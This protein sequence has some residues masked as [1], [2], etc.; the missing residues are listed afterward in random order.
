M[1][2]TRRHD[3]MDILILTTKTFL[4]SQRHTSTFFPQ[5]LLDG[6]SK[7]QLRAKG[8]AQVGTRSDGESLSRSLSRTHRIAKP[9]FLQRFW[10]LFSKT[11][12][13]TWSADFSVKCWSEWRVFKTPTIIGDLYTLFQKHKFLRQR[14][15]TFLYDIYNVFDN[16]IHW[17]S[18][19]RWIVWFLQCFGHTLGDTIQN[20][21][22]LR[23]SRHRL[24]AGPNQNHS[25]FKNTVFTCFQKQLFRTHSF[26]GRK[27]C[28]FKKSLACSWSQEFHGY[29]DFD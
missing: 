3:S 20:T 17:A 13:F 27:T 23:A 24:R 18:I 8:K 16:V 7:L 29:P 21:W 9:C 25:F 2:S 5:A 28:S 12:F 14:R 15:Q 10:R 4:N 22:F 11:V 26:Y 6:F 1:Q 19:F